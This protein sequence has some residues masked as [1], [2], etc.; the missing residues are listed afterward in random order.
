[1]VVLHAVVKSFT[2]VDVVASAR[3]TGLLFTFFV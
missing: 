2:K 3:R 1:M